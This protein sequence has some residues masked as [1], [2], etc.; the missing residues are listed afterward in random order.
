MIGDVD[1]SSM[2]DRH[3]KGVLELSRLVP[4][5]SPR[6]HCLPGR[7]QLHDATVEGVSNVHKS[8]CG[9]CYPDRHQELAQ[10]GPKSA[11]RTKQP[12]GR[13]EFEHAAPCGI[14]S[15]DVPACIDCHTHWTRIIVPLDEP[16][17]ASQ[18]LSA[19]RELQDTIVQT[20]GDIDPSC[21]VR[22]HGPGFLHVEAEG[23]VR[24]SDLSGACRTGETEGQDKHETDRQQP[25]P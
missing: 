24:P 10:T 16:A 17:P 18:L 4:P 9:H 7:R 21:A 11:E 14:C 20:I 12:T 13:R 22:S 15:V 5:C 1:V 19:S 25:S 23:T 8:V 6:S 3:S 2:V